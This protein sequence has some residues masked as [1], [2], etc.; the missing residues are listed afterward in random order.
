LVRLF[1]T[2]TMPVVIY[3]LAY[4]EARKDDPM[5]R[6]FRDWILSEMSD[7]MPRIAAQ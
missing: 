6:T 7:E 1:D 5:I 3:S 2:V 4:P